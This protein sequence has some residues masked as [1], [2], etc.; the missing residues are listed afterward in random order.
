MRRC[1]DT[2]RIVRSH[3]VTVSASTDGLLFRIV[4]RAFQGMGGSGIYSVTFVV[5]AKTVPVEKAGLYSSAEFGF[6]DC[7]FAGSHPRRHYY[8][9][10]DLAL[11]LLVEVMISTHLILFP[12][13]PGAVENDANMSAYCL[14]FPEL[15][16][17]CLS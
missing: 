5:M 12:L 3:R 1:Q 15:S 6:C 16:F 8:K 10:H 7:Q 4:F 9:P 11:D 14:V 17:P 2:D 13:F